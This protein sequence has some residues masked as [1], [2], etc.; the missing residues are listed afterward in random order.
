MFLGG[1]D[2]ETLSIVLQI[3]LEDLETLT[4]GSKGKHCEGEVTDSDMAMDLY[5][6]ELEA[7][8]RVASDRAMCLSIAAAVTQRC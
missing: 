2:P 5:K 1:L 8:A 7:C 4:T 6:S 3:Q